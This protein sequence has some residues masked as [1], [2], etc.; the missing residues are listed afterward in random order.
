M[1]G[2]ENE[3]KRRFL[4]RV[5]LDALVNDALHPLSLKKS[6]MHSNYL[7]LYC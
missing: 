6:K 7:Y 3:C 4:K 1:L 5:C 2:V